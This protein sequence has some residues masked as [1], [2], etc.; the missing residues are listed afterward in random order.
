MNTFS[1][2]TVSVSSLGARTSIPTA[3][4][5]FGRTL[6]VL[7]SPLTTVSLRTM[8]S[9]TLMNSHIVGTLARRRTL[10]VS[11]ICSRRLSSPSHTVTCCHC[12]VLWM[13]SIGCLL[14]MLTTIGTFRIRRVHKRKEQPLLIALCTVIIVLLGFLKYK[15][16]I[17]LLPYMLQHFHLVHI[18]SIH[19]DYQ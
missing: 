16:S 13:M 6:S 15:Y 5:A 2:T 12:Q 10:S 1:L 7:F 18:S 14:T 3:L 8:F 17:H 19:L 11:M 4:R 9:V